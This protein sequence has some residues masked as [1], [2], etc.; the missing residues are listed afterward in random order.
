MKNKKTALIVLA[1]AILIL[2]AAWLA[3]GRNAD[4][5]VPVAQDGIL[6]LSR[7]DFDADGVVPLRGQWELYPGQFVS[8]GSNELPNAAERRIA[9][10]PG[11]WNRLLGANAGK[12]R[13]YATYRLRI[14]L[15]PSD[16]LYGVKT[17]NIRS[18]NRIYVNG[19]EIGSNGSPAATKATAKER[20]V[21]YTGFFAVSADTIEMLVQV[22]N[23]SYY[24]GGIVYPMLFGDAASI[25]SNDTR[26]HTADWL[27]VAGFSV[28]ILFFAS[29]YLLRKNEARTLFIMGG[30]SLCSLIYVVTHGEK[31]IDDIWPSL[32]YELVLR[33]QVGAAIAF[34]FLLIQ[35][36]SGFL[37]TAPGRGFNRVCQWAAAAMLAA[38]V[39]V[40]DLFVHS[41]WAVL[42]F[43]LS[44]T[45]MGYAVLVLS[46]SLIRR[47]PSSGLAALNIATLSIAM[48]GSLLDA[49]GIRQSS[50][51][52]SCGFFLFLVFQA[53]QVAFKAAAANRDNELLT[54]RL[55]TLDG[56][57]DEFLA[58]TSHELRTPLH[59]M[60]NIASSLSEGAAGELNESQRRQ[61]DMIAD[62]GK[63][64]SLLVNDILDF[65][66]LEHHTISYRPTAVHLPSVVQA[67]VAL[68]EPMTAGKPVAIV[69]A[70]S[71]GM[72]L[73]RADEERLRQVLF[74][75]LGNA[76]K[77]TARGQIRIGAET[78]G[79]VVR[80]AIE[81]TGLGIRRER[82]ASLFEFYRPGGG[83]D[84]GATGRGLG[85]G[86][87]KRLVEL[88][89]GTISVDSEPGQGSCFAFT[90]PVWE[91]DG[92]E[93]SDSAS[94]EVA[95]A[96]E[97][98]SLSAAIGDAPTAQ[99]RTAAGGIRGNVMI[100]DDDPV[101]LQVLKNLLSPLHRIV[102]FRDPLEAWQSLSAGE[103]ADLVVTDWSM[104]EMSGLELTRKIREVYALG[105]LPV[106][107]LT[108][109]NLPND[110][111][112]AFTAGINDF[113]AK[114]VDGD[115]LRI[116]VQALL[117]LRSSI[118][119]TVATEM[120]F[121]QAQIKPHFLFNA[122]NTAISFS[123]VNPDK[124][125][126][127]L[128]ELS[129]YLHGSFNFHNRD[130]LTPLRNEWQLVQSYLALE[131]ARFEERMQIEMTADADM[132][133]MLPPLTI[134]PIVENAVRHGIMQKV[135]GGTISV[136]VKQ[137]SGLLTVEVSDDGVGMTPETLDKLLLGKAERQGVG[138]RNI[139]KRLLLLYGKGLTIKSEPNKGTIVRFE[140]P[141]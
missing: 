34:Y 15:P 117:E 111:G 67:V 140:V 79:N 68:L 120:A 81:D 2:P 51:L 106:L 18:S 58:H 12:G 37:K 75:L 78:V 30:M 70:L 137:A 25:A 48:I 121:L 101:N 95:A 83:S 122:L 50:F 10:V 135:E 126:E 43:M 108:A 91:L 103:S 105:E 114:P 4:A 26:R 130:R 125:T 132:S 97:A 107:L 134:Q 61:I 69:R 16:R 40:P 46:G 53:L 89:G 66:S 127:L 31:L 123:P 44:V 9:D 73:L 136:R 49:Y 84:G 93:L 115:E 118:R 36:V 98:A 96:A 110:P 129:D 113:L 27:A 99:E 42:V 6:D 87:S 11:D 65:S 138:L 104:P 71:A 47:A 54:R 88:G 86:I 41:E 60:I 28:A 72:P 38:D 116:R 5:D 14:L 102:T 64:L 20:N 139:Q 100:V 57:K 52:V 33:L 3:A 24:S 13:G 124:T 131:K 85:L 141:L 109:R 19:I 56:L 45:F 82:L 94:L 35:Y 32:P 63:R 29:S 77:F 55:L 21:P 76:V 17:I 22:S 80:I 8:P 59:G 1:L 23:Y 62:A 90:V 92:E 119:T 7:W 128:M 112:E 133:A 39:F 74:N